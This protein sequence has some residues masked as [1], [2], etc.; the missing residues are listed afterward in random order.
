MATRIGT[1]PRHPLTFT[2]LAGRGRLASCSLAFLIILLVAQVQ[3]APPI[4]ALQRSIQQ[5]WEAATGLPVNFRKRSDGA[6][7]DAMPQDGFYGSDLDDPALLLAL[8]NDISSNVATL[9]GLY[10]TKNDLENDLSTQGYIWQTSTYYFNPAALPKVSACLQVLPSNAPIDDRLA[11]CQ[12]ILYSCKIV[13]LQLIG[14]AVSP[15]TRDSNGD[16]HTGTPGPTLLSSKGVTASIKPPAPGGAYSLAESNWQFSAPIPDSNYRRLDGGSL[17]QATSADSLQ[18][19][20]IYPDPYEFQSL[21][22][23][24]GQVCR[25]VGEDVTGDLKFYLSV[26]N[27]SNL[28]GPPVA[29]APG[30]LPATNGPF[31]LWNTQSGNGNLIC[32]KVGTGTPKQVIRAGQTWNVRWAAGMF[33]GKF[34]DDWTPPCTAC[35][36]TTGGVTG[37]GGTG[38]DLSGG[39]FDASGAGAPASAGASGMNFSMGLGADTFGATAGS[40]SLNSSTPTQG[41]INPNTLSYSVGPNGQ[42]IRVNGVATQVVT[43]SSLVQ[44]TALGPNKLTLKQYPA[45]TVS[46]QADGTYPV[47]GAPIKTVTIQQPV[48]PQTNQIDPNSVRITVESGPRVDVYAYQYTPATGAWKF[49]KGDGASV[50]YLTPI[51]NGAHTQRTEWRQTYNAD[52]VLESESAN[53][54]Q[55]EPWGEVQVASIADPNG[56]ALTTTY[57]YYEVSPATDPTQ[58]GKYSQLKQMVGTNGY[59]ETYDYDQ[60]G[61]RIKVVAQYADSAVAS[62]DGANRVVTTTYAN[63]NPAVTVVETTLG[64][65]TKRSYRAYFTNETR[66]IVCTVPGAA[67][68]ATTNLVTV[69]RTVTGGPFSGQVQSV[70]Q[71][72]GILTTYS[73]QLSADK[74]TKTTTRAAGQPNAGGDTVV[75]GT[76]TIAVVDR[77]GQE[78]STTSVDVAS[79]LTLSSEMRTAVDDLGRPTEFAYDDG[80]TMST[81]I[82]CCGPQTSTDREGVVTTYDYDAL[83]RV[84]STTRDGLTTLTEHDSMGRVVLIKRQGTDGSLQ[85][86]S[87]THYDLAGR[88]VET[89]DSLGRSTRMNEAIDNTGHLVRTTTQPDGNTLIKVYRKDGRQLSTGGTAVYPKSYEYGIEDI[90]PLGG[91]LIHAWFTKEIRLGAGG[92]ATEWTKTYQDMAGRTCQTV[93]ANGGVRSS[94]YNSLGQL[95]TSVDADG[96]TMRYTYA[97]TGELKTTALDM[98]PAANPSG[99]IHFAGTDRIT[100]NVWSVVTAHGVTVQRITTSQ[101]NVDGQ[102]SSIVAS[103]VDMTPNGRHSWNSHYGL[104]TETLIDLHGDGTNTITTT[105]PDGSILIEQQDHGRKTSST[106]KAVNGSQIEGKSYNYGDAFKRLTQEIDARDGTTSHS[107]YADD[108]IQSTTMPA[109]GDGSPAQTTTYFYEALTGRLQGV[110]QPDG[111]V[112]S[113]E[114]WPTGELKKTS[115]IRTYPE[116]YTYDLQGRVK[117]LTTHGAAGASV[118][119]WNYDPVSGFL[120]SKQYADERGPSFGYTLAGR[121]SSRTWARGVATSLAYNGAGEV[122]GVGYSDTTPAKGLSYDRRGQMVTAVDAAG[123]RT[124]GS[125][126]DGQPGSETCIDGTFAGIGINRNYDGL[127]RPGGVTL[128]LGAQ[129]LATSYGYDGASR[130]QSVTNGGITTTYSYVSNSSR[131]WQI[132]ASISGQSL[133]T[134]TKAYDQLDRLSG[135]STVVTGQSA[136][137][138][139]LAY[140]YDLANQR[141]Q[142][143]IADGSRWQYGYDSLGQVTGANRYWAD[144]TAVSGQQFGYSFDYIGNRTIAS[145][146]GGKA[147]YSPNALN[148]Y[149][150]R[151]VPGEVDVLGSAKADA[152]VTVNGATAQRRGSYFAYSVQVDN[153]A[154]PVYPEIN[155]SAARPNGAPGTDLV[156]QKSGRVYIP[157][158][159]ERFNYDADGNLT[160]DGRWN[161]TWDAE[162]QLI[163]IESIAAS[164]AAGAPQ[165]KLTFGYDFAHRRIQ[166]SVSIWNVVSSSYTVSLVIRFVY[167]GW[168]LLAELDGNN[169][170]QRAYGWGLDLSGNLSGAGGVGGLLA[171]CDFTINRNYVPFFDDLGN[172]N[173]LVD[174]SDGSLAAQYEYGPFGEALRTL[175]PYASQNPFR[176]STKY[177]DGETGLLYYGYRYYDCQN[178][179][180]ISRDP[181]EETGGPNVYAFVRNCPTLLVDSDGRRPIYFDPNNPEISDPPRDTPDPLPP[182]PP[183]TPGSDL[184]TQV[185]NL[186]GDCGRLLH[187]ITNGPASTDWYNDPFAAY[188]A[189][190]DGTL[191]LDAVYGPDSQMTQVLM[192]AP[193]VTAARSE[194]RGVMID[195]IM[196]CSPGPLYG[197]IPIRQPWTS[198]R[199]VLTTWNWT[200]QVL[201]GYL[202]SAQYWG[203]AEKNPEGR[204]VTVSVSAQ[205]EVTNVMGLR[206]YNHHWEYLY[207]PKV[208]DSYTPGPYRT[209]TQKFRWTEEFKMSCKC[210]LMP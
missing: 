145:T 21:S 206:S 139:A 33:Y 167:D 53:V 44:V 103:Q 46:K 12:Q 154:A 127:L 129:S 57:S 1:V 20:G 118:T 151:T 170:P 123:T 88:V 8:V 97:P 202:G 85:T 49:S 178:G 132:A 140:G 104:T 106:R 147:T 98:N 179:F 36:C 146:T 143:T 108:Q 133:M 48:D 65:E 165:L 64:S 7:P 60:Y 181:D 54:F 55:T 119:T 6:I 168:N 135:T 150:S 194:I 99:T 172:V 159:P 73:Y 203:S 39:S 157:A 161:Y 84:N 188:N 18:G 17:F 41:L 136:A 200:E 107:Y 42:V 193:P 83:G 76:T 131:V 173:G 177:T 15:P 158:T 43:P 166:K 35:T 192:H 144:G 189:W 74:S 5:R 114:Y 80:T 124:F 208:Q 45:P 69:T 185:T 32:E 31:H 40:I 182:P 86:L 26:D 19:N 13:P 10:T 121:I 180:W 105:F 176:F 23:L 141:T 79:G 198:P 37:S 89:L 50:T 149:G 115:G 130:L 201:G 153:S 196:R 16:W 125:T 72:N 184:G 122:T 205:F 191:P 109:P 77:A 4:E 152:T 207:F 9:S 14:N 94:G 190:R 111:G 197:N 163:G 59:W 29:P 101:W 66:D 91:A 142:T 63:A 28:P 67:W 75:A 34:Q 183:P 24:M 113:N 100:Q 93:Q 164:V 27:N 209:F 68:T 38:G 120:T 56:A 47:G 70:L 71:S 62:A 52:G 175:G 187:R 2:H 78:I 204:G 30:L 112:I 128:A 58:L 155:V 137:V 199:T 81:A 116:E 96:V 90:T 156:A 126:L 169:Q 102:D 134:T 3:A 82:G 162:N 22:G 210:C 61:R 171:I 11:Q 87:E 95:I 117:T 186:M 148:Q 110:R 138:N 92:A 174:A 51:W 25:Y 160:S 195:K